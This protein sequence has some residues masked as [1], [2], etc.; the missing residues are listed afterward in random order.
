RS[1]RADRLGR[2]QDGDLGR[3]LHERPRP[4]QHAPGPARRGN[5]EPRGGLPAGF[6]TKDEFFRRARTDLAGALAGVRVIEAR[7]T[8]AGPMCA[9]VLADFGADVIKIELPEGEVARRLPPF[10][11]GAE[12]ALSF[13]HTTVNRNKRSVT[14]DLRQGAGRDLFLRL[15]SSADV[16]V[17]NFRPGT[18]DGWGLG[19]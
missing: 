15:A 19:Y 6:L 5:L 1:G 16:V 17:E 10:L 4:E 7:T 8:G 9:C 3:L 18:M 14:L 13:M 2:P 11:P 12:P